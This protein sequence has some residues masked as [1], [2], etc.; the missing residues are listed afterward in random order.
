MNKKCLPG[1]LMFY[2]QHAGPMSQMLLSSDRVVDFAGNA[3]PPKREFRPVAYY[4]SITA[5]KRKGPTDQN[6]QRAP[7]DGYRDIAAVE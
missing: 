2:E 5:S 3:E 6:R 1:A 4:E 7:Y